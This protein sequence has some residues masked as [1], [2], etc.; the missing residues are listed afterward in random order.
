MSIYYS[1]HHILKY[2]SKTEIT[3]QILAWLFFSVWILSLSK[4]LH[5]ARFGETIEGEKR[6]DKDSYRGY[7][8][9]GLERREVAPS[10]R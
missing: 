2:Y 4:A 10:I 7:S 3:M 9:A 8:I 1:S 6:R 5:L